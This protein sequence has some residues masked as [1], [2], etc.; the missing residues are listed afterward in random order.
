M[1]RPRRHLEAVDR[2]DA[3]PASAPAPT[4]AIFRAPPPAPVPLPAEPTDDPVVR[5]Q[6]DRFMAAFAHELRTPLT[7]AVGWLRRL[8]GEAL[9]PASA[10]GVARVREALDRLYG[11]LLDVELLAAA[12]LGRL[13]LQRETVSVGALLEGLPPRLARVEGVGDDIPVSVDVALCR[14]VVRELADTAFLAPAPDAVHVETVPAGDSVELRVVRDADPIAPAVLQAL[15]APF[16]VA[17]GATGVTFG[18]YLAR[19]LVVAHGG[20][21]GVDQDDAHAVLWARLP[22]V[23]TDARPAGRRTQEDL[24]T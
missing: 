1:P 3:A 19:A 13:A 4:P 15:F 11:R 17:D 9:D 2:P 8:D 14:R 10:S 20:T 16:E 22:V 6:R 5:A 24:P 7:V 21:L 18:L 23:D 12:S